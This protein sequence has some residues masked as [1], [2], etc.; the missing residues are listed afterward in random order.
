[1]K[2]GGLSD[3]QHNKTE[4][5]Y[6]KKPQILARWPNINNKT[7]L[8][9]FTTITKV[10]NSTTF[11]Y[12]NSNIFDSNSNIN[13]WNKESNGWMHG[14]WTRDWY[15]Y[16]VSID[17]IQQINNNNN[18]N[19]YQI[20]SNL[21]N[22][23]FSSA[24]WYAVNMLSELDTINEYYIDETSLILYWYPPEKN[25]NN[26]INDIVI[27][28]KDYVIKINNNTSNL[29]FNNLSIAYS[30]ITGI[31]QEWGLNSNVNNINITNCDI[32]NHGNNAIDIYG[33]NINILNNNIN[34]VGCKGITIF[35]GNQYKLISGNNLISNNTIYNMARWK[36]TYQP[37]IL[38]SGIGNIYSFNNIT[39]S[40]HNGISGGGNVNNG[41]NNGGCNNIFEYNYISNTT[42]ETIDSGSFQSDGGDNTGWINRGNIFR[43]N[44]FE[45]IR[46]LI[47]VTNDNN[48]SIQAFEIDDEI[49][50]WL[51]YN[52][53]FINC[54]RG[55]YIG[56]GRRNIIKNNYF[57]DVDYCVRIDNRGMNIQSNWCTPPNG[58]LWQGL[59]SV[60][61]TNPPWSIQYPE[62]LNISNEQPC[63]PVYNDIEN[64]EYCGENTKFT[65]NLSQNIISWNDTM[66]N[67]VYKC[68]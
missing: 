37:G 66:K 62:L 5:F 26:L 8:F 20:T 14:Y 9:Q 46:N 28:I 53:T 47:P 35:G 36:R 22:N 58:S 19:Y 50:G 40:P 55:I 59:Y 12:N 16:Y 51:I 17:N 43:F 44:I 54:Q 27:S 25:K 11:I 67:N 24:R 52:N 45:N 31:Y 41:I 38:W 57:K 65:D 34:N 4:L 13:K 3:C 23:P 29:V 39:Y 18:N 15:D 6:N 30:K 2:S 60:N 56:G 64:N 1:M 7:N 42:F 68:R 10:I 32:N 49:S 63:V 21:L 48:S 33:I 61:Y